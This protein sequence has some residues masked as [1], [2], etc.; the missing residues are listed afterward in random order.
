[1]ARVLEQILGELNAVY[2]PQRDVYNAQIN[3]LQPQQDA[4]LQGLEATKRDSFAQVENNANRK[5]LYYSGIPVAEQASYTGAQYLPAVA[6]LK[7]RYAQQRFNLQNA[8]A[9]IT[10][11]QYTTAYGIRASEDEAD[12]RARA[13]RAGGGGGGFDLGGLGSAPQ[14][15]GGGGGVEDYIGLIRSLRQQNA[16]KYSWGGIAD[17]LKQR[18]VNVDN[19]SAADIALHQYFGSTNTY[20]QPRQS[21]GNIVGRNLLSLFGGLGRAGSGR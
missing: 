15:A 6:N 5:G 14:A 16:G 13:A 9:E 1:M 7:N 4:E 17:Y 2:N 19:G 8:L 10:Q 11:K 12:A 21:T 18:G 3:A 20:G